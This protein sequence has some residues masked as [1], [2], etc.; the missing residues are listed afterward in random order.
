MENDRITLNHLSWLMKWI[1]D[2]VYQD[3]FSIY[4]LDDKDS[5]YEKL[6]KLSDKE[7]SFIISMLSRKHWFKIK[8][9]LSR[10]LIIK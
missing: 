8:E 9:V 3:H 10:K 1:Y 2:P 4:N 7:Y 5:V 6:G